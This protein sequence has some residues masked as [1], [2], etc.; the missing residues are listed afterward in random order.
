MMG[1]DREIRCQNIHMISDLTVLTAAAEPQIEDEA[2]PG[3]TYE[4]RSDLIGRNLISFVN[5]PNRRI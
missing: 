2:D 1:T 3:S 4:S 5:T